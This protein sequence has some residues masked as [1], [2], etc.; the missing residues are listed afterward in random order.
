MNTVNQRDEVLVV[1]HQNPDT[2]SIC[3]AIAYASFKNEIDPGTRYTACRAGEV[4]AETAWVLSH[5][6]LDF[7]R[8]LEDVSP[9]VR[10]MEI[11]REPGISHETTVKRAWETMRDED[12]STLPIVDKTGRLEGIITLKDLA[13]AQMDHEDSHAL[14]AAGTPYCNMAK[15]LDGTVISG[16]EH[17][18]MEHGRVLVGAGSADAIREAMQPGDLMLVSN[19]ECSQVVSLESDAGCLVVCAAAEVT[20]EILAMAE[21]IHCVVISTPYDTFTASTRLLQ[22]VPVRHY[23]VRDQVHTFTLSTPVEEV[24]HQMGALRHVYFPV[25]DDKGLY[26]G[27]LSRRN[28]IN[29]RRKQLILV[30][31][32]EKTQCVPGWEQADIR[33][34]ID[35]HRIGGLQTISPIYFRN[36]PVGSTAT[37]VASMYRE[38]GLTPSPAIAGALCCAIL[39]DTLVFRSPTCTE[40]DK[41]IAQ[42]LSGLCG[43]EAEALGEAMFEA[44]ENLTGVAPDAL[45]RRDYKIFEEG[46]YRFGVSQSTFLSAK[47]REDAAAM[48]GQALEQR[49][50]EDEL[51]AVYYLLTDIRSGGSDVL[52]AGVGAE[53]LLRQGF[54]LA[55]EAPLHLPGVVSRKKQ[56][57]PAVIQAIRAR[58]DEQK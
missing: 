11:R 32:N 22:A 35:H 38:R 13:V 45:L 49:R 14:S 10:D 34:I 3:A 6:G 9:T 50:R 54:D 20:P 17:S 24:M 29:R 57:V 19:R 28:L 48:M 4:S 41:I 39:S 36:Q 7:P 2:D 58:L 42:W 26:Y 33:E 18:R 27:M 37:I 25:L 8:L 31:H 5:F 44:G 43:E 1:G 40:V 51:S 16:D 47:A 23:M 56:F 21:R 30:D 53:G 15:V 52:C 12:I 55:A 46:E